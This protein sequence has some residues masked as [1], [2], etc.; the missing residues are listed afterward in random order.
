MSTLFT[1]PFWASSCIIGL[2]SLM[3]SFIGGFSQSTKINI[4]QFLCIVFSFIVA[5]VLSLYKIKH[6]SLSQL[7]T[8]AK[9]KNRVTIFDLHK[10][11]TTKFTIFN[12]LICTPL[13]W[14]AMAGL[15][16]PNFKRYKSKHNEKKSKYVFL[17]D[18]PFMV[19]VNTIV[20][21]SGA[22]VCFIFFFGCDPLGSQQILNKNQIGVYWM[23]LIL[24]KN[25][26]ILGGLLFS[27][28]LFYSLVHHSMGI[29]F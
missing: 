4:F 27:S 7:W 5:I 22:F 23:H 11:F 20:F 19:V 16:L 9:M 29:L 3:G 8:L 26:P 10:D 6:E 12:Q 14:T 21:V 15:F 2:Y 28:L 25:I 24:G 1:I 17:S 13:P 18:L